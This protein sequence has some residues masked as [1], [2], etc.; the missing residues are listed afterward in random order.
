MK[1][2]LSALASREPAYS[3][4]RVY[5]SHSTDPKLGPEYY[6]RLAGQLGIGADLVRAIS[7]IES[8]EKGLTDEGFPVV[9]FE[10]HHWR[11]R[12]LN[13]R[14]A[15]S[16]DTAKNSRDLNERWRM[17]REMHEVD[18]TAA[19]M[20]HSF[21]WAQIMGFNHRYCG[22]E[23][24]DSFLQA[25]RTIEGQGRAFV[26]FV[27]DQ[28]TLHAAMR[29]RNMQRVAL[30]YNGRNYAMNDYDVK[31]ARLTSGGGNAWA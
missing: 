11:K 25:M 15:K 31:L 8:A 10:D 5:H 6:D 14:V 27:R 24:A 7:V 3:K 2:W 1:N 23:H 19:I 12:R 17:F 29:D 21:G 4:A 9:R 30:H 13:T 20:S 28:T 22:F 16:F 26:G 18:P